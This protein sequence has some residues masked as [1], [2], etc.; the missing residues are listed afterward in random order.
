MST[1]LIGPQIRETSRIARRVAIG[2]ANVNDFC[3]AA[4]LARP[5]CRLIGLS[6]ATWRYERRVD[7]TNARLRE[8]LQVH[9]ANPP[10]FA[11]RPASVCAAQ[12]RTA[13]PRAR[14]A[15][16]VMRPTTFM[17]GA[18]ASVLTSARTATSDRSTVVGLSR[19]DAR[20]V[21]G[22]PISS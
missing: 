4:I 16:A 11:Y 12:D 7:P 19:M 13:R 1:K 18:M 6:T 9:A 2:D 8:Q 15:D 17:I 21:T 10:R 20:P 22:P 3:T 5:T 14:A